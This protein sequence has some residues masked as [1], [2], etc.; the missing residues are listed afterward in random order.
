MS[1]SPK[2]C[3]LCSSTNLE[4]VIEFPDL[5]LTD[6]LSSTP[7]APPPKNHNQHLQVCMNCGHAQLGVWLSPEFLYG[8]NYRYRTAESV[9]GKS[10]I[11]FFLNTL[12]INSYKSHFRC[13]VEI[14][15]NDLYLLDQL[16]P[17]ANHLV[18][19]DPIL[20][21]PTMDFPDDIQ[22][23]AQTFENASFE[24]NLPSAPDLLICRH[25][26]EHLPDPVDAISQFL[27]LLSPD[28][29]VVIEIPSLDAL[30][31]KSR[32]DQ[33]FH[34]HLHYFGR[35]R[36]KSIIIKLGGSIKWEATSW[37]N[38]GAYI[39]AFSKAEAGQI[40]AG[41]AGPRPNIEGIREQYSEFSQFMASI[42]AHLVRL[43]NDGPVYGFGAAQM[44]PVLAWHLGTNFEWLI[45]VLDDD[46]NKDGLKYANLPVSVAYPANDEIWRDATVVVTAVDH[47][48]ALLG[49][50]RNS[51]P[52][53]IVLPLMTI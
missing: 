27:D 12:K 37:H 4:T 30:M 9:L 26:L 2:C 17:Y 45:S 52:K 10:E 53:Q 14:G 33:I 18:G 29:I 49:R 21:D 19:V 23:I 40:D 47:A 20:D 43:S 28:G 22:V 1:I 48:P 35:E 11:S 41:M 16:R 50:L 42:G 5:P 3:A 7:N 24:S 46:R 39:V 25:T 15:C 51:R 34:Q 32:F 6:T 8:S 36:L 44:L 31:Q 13:A 38:W